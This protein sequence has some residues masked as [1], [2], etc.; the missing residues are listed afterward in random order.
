MTTAQTPQKHLVEI[1]S[2]STLPMGDRMQSALLGWMLRDDRVFIQVYRK[3]QP[4]W[5]LKAIHQKLYGLIL[6]CNT[7]IGHPP[8]KA[9]LENYKEVLAEDPRTKM[10]ILN[11]INRAF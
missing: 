11:A 10:E 6:K 1:P 7:Y 2:T 4:S 9:E 5:F 3:V 8:T